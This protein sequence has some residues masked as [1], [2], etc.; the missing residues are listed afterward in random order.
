MI[1]KAPFGVLTVGLAI[2]DS[3][4]VVVAVGPDTGG[5]YVIHRSP[6]GRLTRPQ[7][8]VGRRQWIAALSVAV[9]SDGAMLLAWQSQPVAAMGNGPNIVRGAWLRPGQT[10]FERPL[11]V[12]TAGKPD[13]YIT[14]SQN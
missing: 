13:E 4:A 14:R 8:L 11:A 1:G 9:D 5:L 12:A 7:H 3:G 10:A 6:S 2:S